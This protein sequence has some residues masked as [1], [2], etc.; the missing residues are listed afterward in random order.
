[1]IDYMNINKA[2]YHVEWVNKTWDTCNPINYDILEEASMEEFK[3]IIL[4]KSLK[5]WLYSGDKDAQVPYTDTVYHFK[6]LKRKKQ[7]NQEPWFVK[8]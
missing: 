7:G 4:D 1:M 3:Q 8:G 5:V 6:E 2:S